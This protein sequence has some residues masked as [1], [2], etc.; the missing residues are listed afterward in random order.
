MISFELTEDQ[1]MILTTAREFARNELTDIARQCDEEKR[2][3]ESILNSAWKLGLVNACIPENV[4]GSG[5]EH[6]ALTTALIC[7]ELGY[8]CTSLASA[9]MAPSAFIQ[10]LITFG[11]NEQKIKYLPFYTGEKFVAAAA[12]LQE[13]QFTF[14]PSDMRTKA[15]HV[16]NEWVINGEKRLVPFGKTAEHF[17]V[18]AKTGAQTGDQGLSGIDAFIV[19]SDITGLT[20]DDENERT[21]GLNPLQFSRLTLNDV[22]VSSAARL[23]GQNG[24]DGRALLNSIR[25][26]NSA[27][28]VGLSK[29]V[30]EYSIPYAKERVAFGEPIAKKQAIAFMLSEMYTETES[31]RWMVWKAACQ[32]DQGTDATKATTLARHYTNKNTMQIADNGVQIFGG[33][34]FIRD[35]PLE[36]WFRN[37]RTLTVIEGLAAA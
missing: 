3:P 7:E 27:L 17:L 26:A 11:T 35:L 5:I 14:D 32:L 36:M 24:I 31:M 25:I 33:H 15:A 10:P 19:P 1:Q 18:L 20:I 30:T 29:A 22:V 23:G 28:C 4:G 16:R 6:S 34:G 12:A 37:A 2:V 21:M 8:G 13:S 9:I